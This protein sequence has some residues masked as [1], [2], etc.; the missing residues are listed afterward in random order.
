[1]EKP[2]QPPEDRKILRGRA[3]TATYLETIPGLPEYEGNPFIEALPEIW[4]WEG[5]EPK[6]LYELTQYFWADERV[7]KAPL[8]VRQHRLGM[9]KL[10]FFD[11]MDRVKD[12][13]I[14][15]SILLRQS[16]LTRN[17]MNLRYRRNLKDRMEA[18][19]ALPQRIVSVGNLGFALLGAPG[20]GK[21][22]SIER[23]LL[24]YPQVIYHQNYPK[25]PDFRHTQLVWIY[26]TCSHAKSA[27]GLCLA[28][29]TE[30]DAIL[31]TNFYGDYAGEN[32]DAL[33]AAMAMV[34]GRIGLGALVVD[35]LEFL[36]SRTGEGDDELLKFLVQLEN[37]MRIAIILVGTNKAA[38]LLASN[39]HQ[40]RRSVGTGG[41]IWLPLTP[42][43]FDWLNFM[44][45]M[46]EHQYL[47][48]YVPWDSDLARALVQTIYDESRGILN[49]AVDLFYYAQF[50][51]MKNKTETLTVE[52]II[53]AAKDYQIFNRPYIDALKRP[54]LK[55]HAQLL[56]DIFPP[57]F[58]NFEAFFR[59]EINAPPDSKNA[60]DVSIS[61]NKNDSVSGTQCGSTPQRKSTD[62]PIS[63][64]QVPAPQ[65]PVLG[66]VRRKI[67]RGKKQKVQFPQ[68]SIMA[69]CADALQKEGKAPYETLKLAGI[70]RSAPD[71]LPERIAAGTGLVSIF[72]PNTESPSPSPA[73]C[74][75]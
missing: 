43:D 21:T 48:N 35:E 13:E 73:S 71:F 57:D 7:R 28:F 61:G 74:A 58:E 4:D 65:S 70:I 60:I 72:L 32:K 69:I 54:E 34:A 29:F 39:P 45:T 18:M 67:R 46:W 27:R 20:Q 3:E 24:L 63:S 8:P 1:M 6:I 26:L 50:D 68:G 44:E 22:R 42:N 41:R 31:G 49:Y 66:D 33:V 51:A 15:L 12:L 17:P 40:A 59:D 10:Q 53:R 55:Q 16:Y 52:G 30:V 19:K 75:A 9:F 37:T 2:S 25:D 64:F 14:S 47:K 5:E 11:V 36:V 38:K 23:I 62:A 56:A